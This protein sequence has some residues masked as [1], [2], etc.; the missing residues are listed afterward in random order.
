LP[1]YDY[2]QWNPAYFD[3]FR[4]LYD[5]PVTD[6]SQAVNIS[7]STI[8]A[9]LYGYWD[10]RDAEKQERLRQW[11]ATRIEQEYGP[12]HADEIQE[13]EEEK[14]EA[15]GANEPL[16]VAQ[17]PSTRLMPEPASAGLDDIRTLVVDLTREHVRAQRLTL[18]DFKAAMVD[19]VRAR[20]DLAAMQ[21][22]KHGVEIT[23]QTLLAFIPNDRQQ[24]ALAELGK[25]I[26]KAIQR[27]HVPFEL[28]GG[29]GE[30]I[31]QVADEPTEG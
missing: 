10:P 14:Q 23:V 19:L 28:G 21:M 18:A 25:Q 6:I 30:G 1:E 20:E 22:V 15:E 9:W 26:G 7:P 8:E 24:V 16:I 3:Q 5:I 17:E 2:T 11:F 29:R 4:K 31:R 12:L 13:S 27:E